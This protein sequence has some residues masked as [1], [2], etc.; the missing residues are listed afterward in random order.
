MATYPF[1]V[2]LDS[3]LCLTGVYSAGLNNT[4][5]TL[6]HFDASLTKMVLSSAFGASAGTILD[7]AP[8]NG[9]PPTIVVEGDY[10][11]GVVTVGRPYNASIT[12]SRPYVRDPR[13]NAVIDGEVTV[14]E[15]VVQHANTCAYTVRSTYPLRADRTRSFSNATPQEIGKT[16]VFMP[17]FADKAVYSIEN[18][19]PHPCTICAIDW[20]V[21]FATRKG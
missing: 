14:R 21:D 4:T 13:D 2:R 15:I 19:S 11:S 5:F 18:N 3:K 9:D 1:P 8:V 20:T 7:V 12:L 17:G 10:S 16:R 6:P